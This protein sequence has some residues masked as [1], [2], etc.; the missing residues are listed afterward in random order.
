MFFVRRNLI[1]KTIDIKKA[2]EATQLIGTWKNKFLARSPSPGIKSIGTIK[3]ATQT[4]LRIRK[5]N[6]L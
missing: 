1:E 6:I 2:T 4:P 3:P 5:T